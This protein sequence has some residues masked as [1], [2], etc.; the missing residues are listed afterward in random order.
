MVNGSKKI[1]P[2]HIDAEKCLES[3][4]TL[5]IKKSPHYNALK[6]DIVYHK[7]KDRYNTYAL[8]YYGIQRLLIGGSYRSG[9]TLVW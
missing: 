1:L 9:L 7:T 8:L 2:T 5:K 4:F 6:W 3:I